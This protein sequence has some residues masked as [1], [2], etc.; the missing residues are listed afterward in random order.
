MQKLQLWWN[1]N[2]PIIPQTWRD[3]SGCWLPKPHKPSTRLENL[4][5]LGLQKP[6]GKAVL[7]LV[8][9]KALYQT[10]QWLGTYPQFAYLPFRSTRDSILRG[11]V[12]CGTVRQLLMHQKRSIHASTLSQPRLHCAGGIMPFLDLHRAF[13]QVPRPTLL[14]ALQTTQLDPRLQCLIIQWRQ[15][16]H[17]HIEVNN[18]CRSIPVSRGVRQGCSIAP[19]LWTAVMA[20]LIDD[21]QH[22]IPRAWL[23]SN[24]TIYAD[25]IDVHCVFHNISKLTQA[26]KYFEEIIAAI[27]RLGLQISPSK[28][29]VIIRGKGPGYEKWKKNH[30]CVDASKLH[31]LV[32]AYNNMKIPLKKKQLYLGIILS[33]DQFERQTVEVRVQAGWNNFKRLQPWLCRKHHMSLKLRMELMRTCIIPTVCYGVFYTGLQENGINLICQTLHQMY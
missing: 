16:T 29:C 23:S 25:D 14:T 12:H 7:K 9:K 17:Y 24:L 15:D 22:S 20:L 5:M 4:G 8:A 2:P 13:E 3:A 26:V 27:E 28:S 31:Y 21:L 30:T 10:L 19:Y 6:L 18:T 33:Y 11:A 1:Q 32:L